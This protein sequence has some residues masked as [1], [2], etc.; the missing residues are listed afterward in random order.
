MRSKILRVGGDEAF[1]F[2]KHVNFF[3]GGV[4]GLM[5]ADDISGSQRETHPNNFIF[6]NL[7]ASQHHYSEVPYFILYLPLCPLPV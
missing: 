2:G 3:R 6:I 5:L 1:G 7:S 4:V